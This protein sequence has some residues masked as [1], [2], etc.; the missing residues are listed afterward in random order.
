MSDKRI[1]SKYPRLGAAGFRAARWL[2]A[3]LLAAAGFHQVGSDYATDRIEFIRGRL[4]RGET[5]YLAGL[6]PP[7]THNSGVALI[8]VSRHGGPRLILNNEEERF[9]GNKH[10]TEYPR[11][12]IDAM[13]A[14]L[15][16][17]GRDVADI[18]AWV[19]TWD[20]PTLFGTLARSVLE[21]APQAAKLLR[22]TEAAGFDGRR[23]EQMTRTPKLLGR[24]LGLSARV[25]LISMPHHENH[26]WF[27][28]SASP[29][30]DADEPVAIAVLDGTG[31]RG[32]ISLYA[33]EKGAIRCLSCNNSAFDS[34]GA[35]YSVISSTQG[36]WTWLSSEGRYMGAAAWG[37]M[38]RAS[39][40][41]YA[42]LRNVL[43]FGEDG[44]IRVNRSLANWYC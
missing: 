35:F 3:K 38:N 29:F 1:G 24:Q 44:E 40:P 31:D 13:V 25:P 39:N 8:E 21:E 41:Y 33:A 15:R 14:T 42:G 5:V 23:L 7:G 17:M 4:Q 16:S 32:S 22:N 9:S 28:F 30:A 36:G 6:G 26:A 34:L 43:H 19:T 11:A 20:Y 10:T 37:D 27:S 2:A 12:S 18:A